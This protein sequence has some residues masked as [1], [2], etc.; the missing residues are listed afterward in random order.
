MIRKPLFIGAA[1]VIAALCTSAYFYYR[2][3][4]GVTP[5][6]DNAETLAL[7]S[8]ITAIVSMTT[9]LVGLLQTI[10][11]LRKRGEKQ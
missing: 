2:I 3:P 6:G 5:Q 10:I 9:A 8:L 7:I 11:G 1:F 4:P